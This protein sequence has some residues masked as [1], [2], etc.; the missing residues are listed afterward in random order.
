MKPEEIVKTI[1][2][3]VALSTEEVKKELAEKSEA[4]IKALEDELAERKSFGANSD[5]ATLAQKKKEFA[6]AMRII[7][8]K[9]FAHFKATFMNEA[10]DGEGGY[11]VPTE[12]AKE[13]LRIAGDY[14]L[15]RKYCRI[16][17]MS[18]DTKSLTALT[19]TVVTYWTDEGTSYTK[20]KPAFGPLVLQARKMTA[21]IPG[22]MELLDD[23]QTDEE[24][25][26]LIAT[27]V[28]EAMARYEDNQVINGD[29][30]GSNFLGILNQADINVITTSGT[31]FS[32]ITYSNLIK[33]IYAIGSKYK[34][35][36][37]RKKIRWRMDESIMG[38]IMDLKDTTG[39]PIL[40]YVGADNEPELLGYGVDFTDTMNTV[41]D[42]GADKKFIFLGD[43]NFYALGN[44][45]DLSIDFGYSSG[46]WEKDIQSMKANKRVAGKALFAGKPFACIKSAAS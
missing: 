46:D 45:K 4:R 8:N 27:L 9:G 26:T 39:Q 40:K 19:G 15:A 42:T 20:S 6:D 16:I 41:A 23:A 22:T 36:A 32:T 3:A 31:A 34:T 33:C 25:R 29:G 10:D 11:L 24:V 38:L 2:D 21:L 35:T 30:T 13:V 17:P 1:E 5:Q 44:R 37:N 12:F 14:G 28:A 43:M 18:G 7:K